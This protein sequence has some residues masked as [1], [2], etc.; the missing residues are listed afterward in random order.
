MGRSLDA[1]T[2]A[3]D[4]AQTLQNYG[5]LRLPVFHS[6]TTLEL[7]GKRG[8]QSKL[9]PNLLEC[10]PNLRTLGFEALGDYAYY[11]TDHSQ[12]WY[13]PEHVPT[14]L[15]VTLEKID[16]G[17]FRGLQCE[18]KVVEYFLTNAKVLKIMHIWFD[19]YQMRVGQSE[20]EY[21]CEV[22]RK[23][24]EIPRGSTSCKVLVS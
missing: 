2:I 18:L 7:D 12:V 1:S 8:L 17:I 16:M 21:K 10:S 19:H 15:L 4:A 20:S 13:P 23:L 3:L 9:L 14:C 11:D 22:F 24:L 6:L 5:G